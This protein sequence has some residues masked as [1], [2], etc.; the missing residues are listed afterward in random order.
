MSADAS[1]VQHAPLDVP[2]RITKV[3]LA[4]RVGGIK[5]R[6]ADEWLR[7]MV[8]AGVVKKVGRVIIGRWRDVDEWLLS[9]G[10]APEQQS[11]GRRRR[12]GVV[13]G[14]AA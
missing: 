9:G 14:G 8:A 12:L 2:Q 10:Q 5:P 6:T 3:S 4:E 13:P 7:R 11:R 1:H